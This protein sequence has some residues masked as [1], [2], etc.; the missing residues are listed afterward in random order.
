MAYMLIMPLQ[1]VNGRIMGGRIRQTS[2]T[3][4]QP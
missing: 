3:S 2:A 4:P 1:V